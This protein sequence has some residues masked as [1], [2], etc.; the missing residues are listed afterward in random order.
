MQTAQNDAAHLSSMVLKITV[1]K[2]KLKN[3]QK[4]VFGHETARER[5]VSN[6]KLMQTARN[7]AARLPG[8]VL[9]FQMV[10]KTANI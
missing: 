2:K 5:S 6:E 3:P 1:F 10:T 9:K 8:M 7:D 4:S